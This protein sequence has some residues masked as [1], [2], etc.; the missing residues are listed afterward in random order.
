MKRIQ[1]DYCNIDPGIKDLVSILN[2]IPF[3]QTQGSGEGHLSNDSDWPGVLP[4]VL[5][6]KGY[7]FLHDGELIFRVDRRYRLARE[8]LREVERL[9]TYYSFVVFTEHHCGNSKCIIEG[10]KVLRFDN[11]DLTHPELIDEKDDY[12]QRI[13]KRFQVPTVVG[14]KRLA[15][16]KQVWSDFH[17]ID[18]KYSELTKMP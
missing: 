11:T 7:K 16:Y 13:K 14:E 8:F 2:E 5:P 4:G 18:K 6:D 17:V 9:P 10:S 3:I 12:G 15:E 1:I